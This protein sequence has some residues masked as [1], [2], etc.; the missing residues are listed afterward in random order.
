MEEESLAER[1]DCSG[2]TPHPLQFE[3]NNELYARPF[4]ALGARVSGTGGSNL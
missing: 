1:R 3:I 2:F 4:E